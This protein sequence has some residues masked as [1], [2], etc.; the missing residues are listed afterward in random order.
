MSNQLRSLSSE[1]LNKEQSAMVETATRKSLLMT[2]CMGRCTLHC[3]KPNRN[4][5]DLLKL[6]YQPS[7]L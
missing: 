1:S 6:L 5:E 2:E 4:L 3:R 7:L